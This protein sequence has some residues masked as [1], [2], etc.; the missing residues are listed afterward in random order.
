MYCISTTKTVSMMGRIRYVKP[1]KLQG[2]FKRDRTAQEARPKF[3][4]ETLPRTG[5][6]PDGRNHKGSQT[7]V[8]ALVVVVVVAPGVVAQDAELQ[9]PDAEADGDV[10]SKEA[11][12][13]EE[14]DELGTLEQ[15]RCSRI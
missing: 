6:Q 5:Q 9:D 13:L 15:S 3:S 8:A 1:P 7:R 14:H 12:Q 10:A 4:D 2:P 11:V